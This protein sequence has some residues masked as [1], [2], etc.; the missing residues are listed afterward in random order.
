M[1]HARPRPERLSGLIPP[2]IPR[3]PRSPTWPPSCDACGIQRAVIGG[4]SLGG[5][6]SLAF[7]RAHPAMTR[8]LMIFDTGPGFRNADAREAWNQRARQ[9]ADD[10]E[11]ARPRG[12]RQQRRG[13]HEPAPQCIRACAGAHAAC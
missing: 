4:L 8:A 2:H 3:P 11:V 7:H 13:A 10:L 9:R 6:M 1:G 12:T 5:Y